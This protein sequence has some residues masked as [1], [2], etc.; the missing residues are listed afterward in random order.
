MSCSKAVNI[1]L[2][3]Q[4]LNGEERVSET[5][6]F[7]FGDREEL[8]SR[9]PATGEELGHVPGWTAE[10]V[11]QAV[12]RAR[13][14]QSAWAGQSLEARLQTLGILQRV[15]VG[16]ADAVAQVIVAEQGKHPVEA[17]GEVIGVLDLLRYYRANA[18]AILRPRHVWPRFG[19]W[20]SHR[21]LPRPHGV[22]GVLSPWNFPFTLSLEPAIAALTAGNAV[23]LKPSE[24]TPLVGQTISTLCRKARLPENLF[25]VAAGGPAIGQALIRSGIDKLVFIG[26]SANGR[27]VAALAGEYLVPVTLELGGKDAAV[28]LEDADLDR[29]VQGILWGAMVNA[30]QACLSIER[31]YVVDTIVGPFLERLTAAARKLRV[32]PTSAAKHDVGPITTE[33]QLAVIRSQVREALEHG[34]RVLCGGQALPG[35]GR[36]FAPTVLTDVPE[37]LAVTRKQTFGPV[38]VV[39]AVA[40][41]EEAVRRVNAS[42]Y[43][44][45]ASVWTRDVARGRALA[46]RFNVGEAAV[47]DHGPSAGHAEIPWGGRKASGYGKTRGPEGLTEMVV[48]QHLSW[49][50]LNIGPVI[51]FPYT[52]QAVRRL[53]RLIPL[54]FGGWRERLAALIR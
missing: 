17:Y 41:G 27:Q 46:T 2:E 52:R 32:G 18:R 51:R 1:F 8:T 14:A 47:N 42:P 43:G 39:Q 21:L 9:N 33:E 53:R 45:T 3:A 50:W 20:R 36:F 29:A 7:S 12:V 37:D 40:D 4:T 49:P 35:P 15:L 6:P 25:Q 13:V 5:A 19:L 10:E 11:R 54:L 30:G 24:H 28:V 16:E 31:V 26:E 22:V 48:W 23:I 44:L 38:V 34:G